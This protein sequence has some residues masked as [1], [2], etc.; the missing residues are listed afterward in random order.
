MA[1]L[2][3]PPNFADATPEL[4]VYRVPDQH[5][6]FAQGQVELLTL[7][8]TALWRIRFASFSGSVGGSVGSVTLTF[9]ALIPGS[10]GSPWTNLGPLVAAAPTVINFNEDYHYS[11]NT[12]IADNY[13]NLTASFGRTSVVG[14]PLM[15]L[16]EDTRI[17]LHVTR[18]NA[19]DG[20][21]TILGG[22]IE[23]ERFRLTGQ[24]L[25]AGPLADVFLLPQ[26]F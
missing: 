20:T 3:L 18:N 4:E 12:D 26:S 19:W 11:W 22:Q 10:V 7:A 9:Q 15:Y 23:M 13:S 16:P 2:A 5:S 1:E 8:G 21:L 6:T 17:S 24:A 14:L 25:Q